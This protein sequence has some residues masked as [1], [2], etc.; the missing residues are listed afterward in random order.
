MV[1]PSTAFGFRHDPLPPVTDNIKGQR[2]IQVRP[3]IGHLQVSPG[4][5]QL[6]SA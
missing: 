5:T 4:N 2:H 3:A 1:L 6:A